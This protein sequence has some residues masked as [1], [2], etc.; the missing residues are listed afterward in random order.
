MKKF[1]GKQK[2]CFITMFSLIVICEV[3]LRINNKIIQI[4][5]VSLVPFIILFGFLLIKN[6]KR[7]INIK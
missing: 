5:G 3:L 2:Y 6:D 1:V 4:V 7:N